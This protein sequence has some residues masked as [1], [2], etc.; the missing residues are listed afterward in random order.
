MTSILCT[1]FGIEM[2]VLVLTITKGVFPTLRFSLVEYFFRI[3]QPVRENVCLPSVAVQ[4]VKEVVPFINTWENILQMVQR[5]ARLST[6]RITS[7]IGVLGMQVWRSL[8]EKNLHP[9]NLHRVQ[10]LEPGDPAQRM[11]LCH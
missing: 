1:D 3:Y 8:H 5:I 6:L 4:S 11:N 10:H 7:R 9:Y 2:H